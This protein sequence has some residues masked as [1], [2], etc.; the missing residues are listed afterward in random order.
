[1]SPAEALT[2]LTDVS[3]QVREA[4]LLERNGAVL[5][6]TLA[7]DERSREV[8]EAACAAL[9]AADRARAHGDSRVTALEAAV[10]GGSLF[11]A[12]GD[13]RVL[14]ATTGQE[15]PAGLVLYDLRSCLRRL[16]EEA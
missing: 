2:E 13:G 15:E 16:Q 11:V 6:S 4:V 9:E 3:T 12:T 1:M 8:A 5:A 14:A 10:P 7:D